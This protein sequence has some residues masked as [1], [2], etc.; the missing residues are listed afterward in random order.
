MSSKKNNTL[1]CLGYPAIVLIAFIS[2]SFV[3]FFIPVRLFTLFIF[4]LLLFS[5]LTGKY[6]EKKPAKY[7]IPNVILFAAIFYLKNL[8]FSSDNIHDYQ[9]ETSEIVSKEKKVINGDSLFILTHQRK[10]KDNYG[11]RFSGDFSIRERD[12]FAS[13]KAYDNH[14]SHLQKMHW[15]NL[16][17]YLI[18]TNTPH[19][20]LILQEFEQ[21]QKQKKLTQFEFAEMVVSFVQDIP[22]SFVFSK[23][24]ESPEK[25]EASIRDILQK[26]QKC[27]IGN[28]PFGIQP[29]TLFMGNLKG[30]CDTRTVLIF[31][32]LN[33]FGYE[34]AI[35][36]SN[37]YKHSI[38]GLHIPAK[39][40]FKPYKGKRYYVWETTSKNFSIG[41]LPS[42]FANIKH[43]N[44]ILTNT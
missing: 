32:I 43:W 39:G 9:P 21:I 1:G 28:I 13:A 37:Y 3:C 27:C 6:I 25:Y 12:Y 15:A 36:N 16:Y 24:C 41:V 34:V 2:S 35:L 18:N 42:N 44:I 26:C 38:L 7:F 8:L 33:H 22:Y 30:D 4:F 19:L 5:W 29:P 20:D 10:W 31:A 14:T 23:Q 40:K 17:A 11:N